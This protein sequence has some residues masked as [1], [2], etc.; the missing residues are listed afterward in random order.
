MRASVR[1]GI[2]GGVSGSSLSATTTIDAR[3]H[4]KVHLSRLKRLKI[5]VQPYKAGDTFVSMQSHRSFPGTTELQKGISIPWQQSTCAAFPIYKRKSLCFWR[6]ILICTYKRVICNDHMYCRWTR[7]RRIPLPIYYVFTF[8]CRPS[9]AW[10]TLSNRIAVIPLAINLFGALNWGRIEISFSC[11]WSLNFFKAVFTWPL[12]SLFSI[13]HIA[14]LHNS[15]WGG[16]KL[17]T[18]QNKAPNSQFTVLFFRQLQ[19]ISE[20]F[21][22]ST[23]MSVEGP[24]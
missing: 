4:W 11:L 22:I 16:Y 14:R 5:E 10:K 9:F 7:L 21:F 2:A 23:V 15:T 24:S 3:R 18:T 17:S 12:R 8:L 6:Y 20:K 1:C 13:W 19:E